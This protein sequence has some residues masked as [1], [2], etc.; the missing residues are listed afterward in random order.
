VDW[1]IARGERFS[2]VDAKAASGYNPADAVNPNPRLRRS[3]TTEAQREAAWQ[4]GF[5]LTQEW[6]D[7]PSGCL[8]SFW[9]RGV[10]GP[11][12]L[13]VALRPVLF[14]PHTAVLPDGLPVS[15]RRVLELRA[16]DR[17]PVD[18]LYFPRQRDL[19]VARD[20]LREAGIPVYEGD[21]S[22]TE[23]HLM[24][25]FVHGS[26]EFDGAVSR[27]DEGVLVCGNP[28][29]RR[30]EFVP[31]LSLL[32]FDI[33]TGSAHQLYAIGYHFVDGAREER[34][35]F[36]AGTGRRRADP[37]VTFCGNAAGALQAF[38]ADVRRLDPDL[39]AGW[40]I[41]DF[42]LPFLRETCDENGLVLALGRRGAPA[43][44]NENAGHWNVQ[45]PGR[46]VVDGIPALRGSFVHFE[47]YSLDA[48]ARETVGQGKLIDF[49]GL[50]T[51]GEIDRLFRDDKLALARY[52][53]RDAELVTGIFQKTGLVDL[54][55]SRSRIS[56]MLLE[57]LGRSVAAFDHFFL[58]RL[59]RKGFVA[60]D[61]DS[62]EPA[63]ALTGGLVLPSQA[64]LHAHVAAFDFRSLYPSIIR[65]FRI[66]P[67]ASLMADTNP[68]CTPVGSSFSGT[69]HILPD[70][71]AE[72]MAVRARARAENQPSLAQAVKILMNSFYGVM[73][74]PASRFY[75]PVLPSSIT[76]TGQWI[77]R[78]VRDYLEARGYAVLYGD[79]DSLFVRLR[80]EEEAEPHAACALLARQATADL[81]ERL[82]RE[83]GVDSKLELEFVRYYRRF[84]LPSGRNGHLPRAGDEPEV[85]GAAPEGAAKRY[86]GLVVHADGREE[87]QV[88]GL[89]SVRSD[90]TPLAQRA[91]REALWRVF[92]GEPCDEWLRSLVRDLRAG[93]LDGELVYRRRLRKPPTAYTHN[94]PPHVRAVLLL[95]AESRRQAGVVNFVMT[96][97]GPV[98]VELPHADWD[99]AHYLDKQVKPAVEDVLALAG[100]AFD[101]ILSGE[102][103]LELF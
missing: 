54:L 102:E 30:G 82:Q 86:A 6:Q 48:V 43:R 21:L 22:P 103:Q 70:Y 1:P 77:L 97:R 4:P 5:L 99:Y 34:H 41:L 80:P 36:I 79:T 91:Q 47:S 31:R 74:T 65:T 27:D 9:G 58:P 94:V 101:S 33:E 50:D 61:R 56:G 20:C 26:C 64:G 2:P 3:M 17:Q 89:E 73:G 68:V 92:R 39:L 53:L 44:L 52:N 88:T 13:R 16:F 19:R 51:Q 11:F 57:R 90:W 98:P 63:E 45:V 78:A 87:L 23:R 18:A 40:N 55:I 93:R 84:Y 32:A 83:C 10:D 71:V 46:V 49:T 66:C 15:E 8:G 25:R 59:H 100:R 85:E 42:D 29:L 35:V 81:A 28:R 7:S 62:I 37:P 24:E 96:L 72:L 14:V 60:P 69:E 76:G 12:E 75:N 67:Y 95:P 38:F